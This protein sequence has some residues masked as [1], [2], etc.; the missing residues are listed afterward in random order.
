MKVSKISS[1]RKIRRVTHTQHL[2]LLKK[3]YV[4]TS[5]FTWDFQKLHILWKRS[6]FSIFCHVT[7][8]LGMNRYRR[9]TPCWSVLDFWKIN[10]EKSSLVNW[11]F[12]LFQTGFLLPVHT[13]ATEGVM[14]LFDQNWW[15]C[16]IFWAKWDGL[17]INRCQKPPQNFF[18]P[19]GGQGGELL[20]QL[21]G[22]FS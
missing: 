5:I 11:I 1:E 4:H 21:G 16:L 20:G 8:L 7:I 18:D 17:D 13:A 14:H 9:Q 22:Q 2:N 12:S 10:L 19:Q 15:F 3:Y 6:T